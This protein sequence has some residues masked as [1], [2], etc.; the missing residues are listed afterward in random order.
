[1]FPIPD[2]SAR[3][4]AL[5]GRRAETKVSYMEHKKYCYR[6]GLRKCYAT[7]RSVTSGNMFNILFLAIFSFILLFS[8]VGH[9]EITF[10]VT[11]IKQ[12][13][14]VDSCT[15]ILSLKVVLFLFSNFQLEFVG[16]FKT[17]FEEF[18]C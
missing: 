17:N 7:C 11:L 14:C 4:S 2:K 3:M 10:L 13:F 9:R 18:S 5:V 15:V 1:M 6:S 16:V 8:L 12:V